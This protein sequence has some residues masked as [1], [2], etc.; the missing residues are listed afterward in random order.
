M[1]HETGD[2]TVLP[3]EFENLRS[4]LQQKKAASATVTRPSK[5]PES[6]PEGSP[7]RNSDTGYFKAICSINHIW[8]Y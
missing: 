6:T 2:A 4:R 8:N 7:Q 3:P 5:T 1:Q